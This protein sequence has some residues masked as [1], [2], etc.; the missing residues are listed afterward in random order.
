MQIFEG[1]QKYLERLSRIEE[2]TWY[3]PTQPWQLK[4]CPPTG[5]AA[6]GEEARYS[7]VCMM[8]L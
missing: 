4:A 2:K 3:T 8:C 5:K 1:S 7:L 6:S